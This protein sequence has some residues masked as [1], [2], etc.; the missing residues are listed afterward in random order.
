[1]LDSRLAFGTFSD[2]LMGHRFFKWMYRNW[3]NWLM[4]NMRLA[5]DTRKRARVKLRFKK[6]A[7]T[8]EE[9][10]S[11]VFSRLVVPQN[12]CKWKCSFAE[13]R[14]NWQIAMCCFASEKV[15]TPRFVFFVHSVCVMSCVCVCHSTFHD[16]IGYVVATVAYFDGFSFWNFLLIKLIHP[17]RERFY[18]VAD[19]VEPI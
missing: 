9:T 17:Q 5:K 6:I 15:G 1:M 8:I 16:E 7:L 11:I 4:K 3:Q 18:G 14:F 19:D 12:F 13:M 2:V 10:R